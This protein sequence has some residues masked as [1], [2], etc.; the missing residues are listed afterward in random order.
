MTTFRS[1]R[2]ICG[3]CK[4]ESEQTILTS[5]NSFGAPDLD[6]RPPPM[7]RNT[8]S[9]WLQECPHCRL[10]CQ[11]IDDPPQGVAV[12]VAE[13]RYLAVVNDGSVSDVTRKFRSWAYLASALKMASEEAFAHL[14]LAWL[15]DDENDPALAKAE[16]SIAVA[17]LGVLRDEG[18]LYPTQPGAAEV[19]LADLW[20]RNGEFDNAIHEASRCASIA[21]QNRLLRICALQTALAK[22][23]DANVHATDEAEAGRLPADDDFRKLGVAGAKVLGK[24]K[25]GTWLR[26][27]FGNS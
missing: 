15:A 9:M 10:V 11:R 1:A 20:R 4:Q 8:M 3:N 25:G 5:T 26:R 2:T 27:L 12:F 24:S 13:P 14:H 6:G 7:K 22:R 17:K 21:K 16:R 23:G 18:K 19:L